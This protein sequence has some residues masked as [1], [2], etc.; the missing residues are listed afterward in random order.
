VAVDD[1]HAPRSTR[2]AAFERG[3]AGG[4]SWVGLLG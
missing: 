4:V 2:R 3:R 1:H